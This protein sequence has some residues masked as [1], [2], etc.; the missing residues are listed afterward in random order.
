MIILLSLL[1]CGRGFAADDIKVNEESVRWEQYAKEIER[2][3]R[4]DYRNGLSYIIS[5]SLAL[6]G[7]IWGANITDDNIEKGIYTVFQTIGIASVGYGAYVWKI[8]GEERNLYATL[9]N[10]R[11]TPE[12][13]TIFLRSY[14]AQKKESEKRERYIKAITHGLI[15]GLN[16][17]NA[18]QQKQDSIKSG[19]YFIGGVNLLA[20]ISFTFEF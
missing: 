12:Q 16:F 5:G 7:G 19:L 18:S 3:E 11:L 13:K 14:Y 20:A 9:S 2:Q 1:I 10:A 15:A 6:G 8:G 4:R 17:Y